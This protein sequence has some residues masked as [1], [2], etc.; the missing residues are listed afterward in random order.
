MRGG[1]YQSDSPFTIHNNNIMISTS[2]RPE[3]IQNALLRMLV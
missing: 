1:L 2:F 3:S